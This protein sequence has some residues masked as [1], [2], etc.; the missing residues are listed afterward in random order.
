MKR[1][2]VSKAAERDLDLI[3]L[4]W[5]ERAGVEVADRLIDAV[6]DR[7]WLVGE[8]PGAGIACEDIDRGVRCFAAGM[9]LIYYKRMRGGVEILHVFDGRR[10]QNKAWKK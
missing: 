6:T 3:F 8:H 1:Y 7:F 5:A 4:Y 2:R 9:H 10:D